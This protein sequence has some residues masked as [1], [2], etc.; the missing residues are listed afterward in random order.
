MHLEPLSP[1]SIKRRPSQVLLTVGDPVSGEGDA[2]GL[3]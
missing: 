1:G 2:I 3:W